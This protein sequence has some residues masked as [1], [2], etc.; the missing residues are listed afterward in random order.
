[1]FVF[2]SGILGMVLVLCAGAALSIASASSPAVDPADERRGGG[3]ALGAIEDAGF[4]PQVEGGMSG[5]LEPG[6]L[7]P[8]TGAVSQDVAAF[9][10]HL[11]APPASPLLLRTHPPPASTGQWQDT[12]GPLR[13]KTEEPAA[14]TGDWACA[15]PTGQP[16]PEPCAVPAVA[17]PRH[18]AG[19]LSQL[20][21]LETREPS[22]RLAG[23]GALE[24]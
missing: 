3:L 14:E 11:P 12:L 18:C 21:S 13:N 5:G 6:T 22:P 7:D 24:V 1:M 8:G 16:P 9:R 17:D 15:P 2:R 23:R 20:P 10:C 4:D 19:G